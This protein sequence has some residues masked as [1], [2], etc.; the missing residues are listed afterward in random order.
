[1]GGWAN[2][3]W[4]HKQQVQRFRL[5]D[6]KAEGFPKGNAA[7]GH[8]QVYEWPEKLVPAGTPP[9]DAALMKDPLRALA[10]TA[11]SLYVADALGGRIFC[12]D[13]TTGEKKSEF[14][15]ALPQAL[16]VDST[17]RIWVGG[18]HHTVTIFS[19]DGKQ[20]AQPITDIGEIEEIAFGPDGKLYVA[21]SV[22]DQVK[23]YDVS[24]DTVTLSHALGHKA[25]P[26]DRAADAFYHLTGVSVDPQGNVVTTQTEPQGG[27]RLAKWGPTGKLL[28]EQFGAEFVSLGNYGP[29]H[30][31][32]FYSMSFHRYKLGPHRSGAWEYTGNE[33]ASDK[34]YKSDPHGVP[35]ILRLG[36]NDFYL[37]AQRRRRAGL[38]P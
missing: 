13:K 24:G 38:S 19:P 29:Q 17:G 28:W 1:M 12:Y 16:A 37:H 30:P 9:A 22:A 14:P 35:R 36:A 2:P 26:G 32:D 7:D 27:A 5:S 25:K 11:D 15:A 33:L 10:A 8:V 3:D 31:D 34:P 21:D 6:G 20:I 18:Q 23:V 4:K